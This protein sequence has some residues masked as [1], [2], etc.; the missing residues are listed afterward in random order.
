MFWFSTDVENRIHLADFDK[1]VCF[2]KNPTVKISSPGTWEASEILQKLKQQQTPTFEASELFKADLQVLFFSL[3]VI[4]VKG[5]GPYYR[6]GR[7]RAKTWLD[8]VRS[9]SWDIDSDGLN[10]CCLACSVF[11]K[12]FCFRLEWAQGYSWQ[13]EQLAGYSEDLESEELVK[14]PV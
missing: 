5:Q 9:S 6:M 2:D 8:L 12:C 10:R 4:W 7:V 11:L 3:W 1:S 13:E 14:Q